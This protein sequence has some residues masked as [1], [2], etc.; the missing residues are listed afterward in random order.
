[1]EDTFCN[2]QIWAGQAELNKL[3]GNVELTNSFCRGFDNIFFF[4]SHPNDLQ[5]DRLYQWK[6]MPHTDIVNTIKKQSP[7]TKS[8]FD[9]RTSEVIVQMA[10]QVSQC[11]QKINS[12]SAIVDFSR[13]PRK[14]PKSTIVTI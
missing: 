4:I 12:F 3:T 14:A 1:M 10:E 8:E 11:K 2:L 5:I 13:R 6:P 7:N 9:T